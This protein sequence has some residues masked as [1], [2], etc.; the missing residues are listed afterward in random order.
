ML[1]LGSS[2]VPCKSSVGVVLDIQHRYPV[3]PQD[4]SAEKLSISVCSRASFSSASSSMQVKGNL[5]PADIRSGPSSILRVSPIFVPTTSAEITKHPRISFVP[6]WFTITKAGCLYYQFGHVPLDERLG[7]P[8]SLQTNI[9][10]L[11]DRVLSESDIETFS[12]KLSSKWKVAPRLLPHIAYTI[13]QFQSFLT[14]F[15]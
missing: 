14:D 2:E 8:Q 4:L 7:Y 13:D 10:N 15:A 9:F 6:E 1:D 12:V 11:V 3:N 5:I